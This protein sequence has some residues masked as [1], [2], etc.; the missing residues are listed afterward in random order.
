MVKLASLITAVAAFIGGVFNQPSVMQS[1]PPQ[2][3][4]VQ[5]IVA[6]VIQELESIAQNMLPSVKVK[7]I[8]VTQKTET[9]VQPLS[10][11]NRQIISAPVP[12]ST[13]SFTAQSFLDATTLTQFERRDGPFEARLETNLGGGQTSVWDFSEASVGTGNSSSPVFA[14]S[15]SCTPAPVQA[16]TGASDQNPT[17]TARTQYACTVS[18]TPQSGTDLRTQSKQFSFTTPAGQLIVT[19]PAAINTVLKDTENDG[20]LVFTNEDSKPITI[21]QMAVDVSYTG[22]ST[23]NGPIILRIINPAT[24]QSTGDY[25]LEN[26]PADPSQQFTFSQSGISLPVSLTLP[27]GGEKL[28][29]IELLGT[30][31]MSIAGV[32]PTVTVKLRGITTNRDDSNIVLN[33]A[34]LSW[35]CVVTFQVYDPNATSGALVAGDACGIGGN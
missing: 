23:V 19:P 16:I 1:A 20:G 26:L 28:L 34:Q 8:P 14:M 2:A 6:P 31:T 12:S 3:A 30:H 10:E 25:H 5:N 4:M 15:Y 17:F 35:S 13:V 9:A 32:N 22:L 18:L 21:N 11:K 33:D 29:P 27:A 7:P 24:G